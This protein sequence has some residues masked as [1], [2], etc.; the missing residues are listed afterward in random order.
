MIPQDIKEYVNNTT[1]N[2]L[3]SPGIAADFPSDGVSELPRVG[4]IEEWD[5]V[6]LSTMAMASHPVHLHLSQFQVLNRQ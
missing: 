3:E 6:Y 2:G 5:I 1:W 4:S